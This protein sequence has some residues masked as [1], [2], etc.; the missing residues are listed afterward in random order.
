[1]RMMALLFRLSKTTLCAALLV[2]VLSGVGSAAL[3]AVVNRRLSAP[4][5][6]TAALAW[7]FAALV[8]F[9]LATNLASRLLLNRLA[10]RATH[11]MRLHLCGRILDAPLRRLEEAGP[12]NFLAVLIQEVNSV[13]SA[14]LTLPVFCIN[15]TIVAGCMIY[16]GWLSPVVLGVLVVFMVLAVTGVQLIQRRGLH[17]LERAR[18]EWARLVEHFRALAEGTKELKLHRGR[19]EAFVRDCVT[20]TADAYRRHDHAAKTTYAFSS[21]WSH[22]LYFVFIGAILFALPGLRDVDLATLSGFTLVALYVRTPL[23]VM[24]DAYPLFKRADAALEQVRGLA[25]ALAGGG[26]GEEAA[27]EPVAFRERIDLIGV[28]YAFEAEHDE[29]RFVLGPIE[30]SIYPGELVFVVGGNGSGKTTL[31]KLLTGLYAPSSGEVALDGVAVT[32][33]TR[34]RYRQLFSAVFSDFHLFE[35]LGGIGP[36]AAL[37]SRARDYLT[38]LRLE[39][40]VTVKGGRLS[41]TRLSRGQR[42]RLALLVACLEDRPVCVLDEWAAD[43]DHAFREIFYRELLEE[44]RARGKTVIVVT[45]DERYYALA[46]RIIKLD[47]GKLDY[48]RMLTLGSQRPVQLPGVY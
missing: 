10:E 45:H 13:A 24:L 38:K 40:K 46:D 48:D 2:G 20:A 14:M 8:F 23:T 25:P 7:G 26:E 44:L 34:D 33:A 4:A 29:G 41:T 16:L 22:V 39:Q 30:V 11:E 17:S 32:D 18:R 37:E 6:P 43:Q 1:M 19:R 5:A 12:H 31:A 35:Q 15:L 21:S 27:G 28:T 3:M 36:D 42:K 9:V 47:E